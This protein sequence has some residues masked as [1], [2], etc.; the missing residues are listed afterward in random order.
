MQ[1][2]DPPGLAAIQKTNGILTCQDHVLQVK[3]DTVSFGFH[4][5]KFFQLGNVFF[6]Q[7]AADRKDHDLPLQ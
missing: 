7:P 5:D 1:Q 6:V 4:T 3:D 2:H